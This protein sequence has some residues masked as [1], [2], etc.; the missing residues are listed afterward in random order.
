M[1]ELALATW[2]LPG[3]GTLFAKHVAK[4]ILTTHGPRAAVDPA[5]VWAGAF[6]GY[7]N[8]RRG[9]EENDEENNGLLPG[10]RRGFRSAPA[11]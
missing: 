2:R 8:G 3:G 1:N 6:S 7:G 5:A 4:L 11:G 10:L 9:E